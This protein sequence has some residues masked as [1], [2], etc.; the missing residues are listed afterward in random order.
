MGWVRVISASVSDETISIAADVPNMNGA[1]FGLQ[2]EELEQARIDTKFN[3]PVKTM[4]QKRMFANHLSGK[5]V[6]IKSLGGADE[7]SLEEIARKEKGKGG[8]MGKD[9]TVKWEWNFRV[10]D[11]KKVNLVTLDP[12]LEGLL[13][14]IEKL[15]NVGSG[16]FKGWGE[17]GWGDS[18][19]DDE[20]TIMARFRKGLATGDHFNSEVIAPITGM[21][22]ELLPEGTE[23][24]KR[25]IRE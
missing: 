21:I 14:K 17:L 25:K 23:Y 1:C 4:A 15:A 5:Y 24:L 9:E 16:G 11:K 2:G 20:L 6:N 8:L 13:E 22:M 7:H 12:Q 10:K 19:K 3:R 18:E